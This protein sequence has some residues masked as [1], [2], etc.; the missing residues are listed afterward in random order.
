MSPPH[1]RL[2][3]P[4][5]A[6]LRLLA[7]PPPPLPCL[8]TQ[9]GCTVTGAVFENNSNLIRTDADGT[10]GMPVRAYN[11]NDTSLNQLSAWILL[12]GPLR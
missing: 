12:G 2:R 11:M 6:S 10:C 1:R 9:E 4:S 3:T 5:V 7:P 8:S